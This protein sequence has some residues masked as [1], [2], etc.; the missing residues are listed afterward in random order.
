MPKSAA[1]LKNFAF[2]TRLLFSFNFEFPARARAP[3]SIACHRCQHL[4]T[5][6]R[7]ERGW[8]EWR[9][10]PW[11]RQDM[12]NVH[13]SACSSAPVLLFPM[14]GLNGAGGDKRGS[15]V[16]NCYNR[17]GGKAPVAER[18]HESIRIICTSTG[19]RDKIFAQR[20]RKGLE[21]AQTLPR[22]ADES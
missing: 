21:Y 19:V 1:F 12:H 16:S 18:Q 9:A 2:I 22:H 17:R 7:G 11:S 15:S 20:W 3:H 14:F 10:I 13:W 5:V 8:K 4:P 6:R